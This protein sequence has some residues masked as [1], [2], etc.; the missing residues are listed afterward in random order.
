MVVLVVDEAVVH[1]D[2]ESPIG[3]GS[4]GVTLQA[5][6]GRAEGKSVGKGGLEVHLPARGVRE[7][8]C[9]EEVDVVALVG[10]LRYLLPVQVHRGFHQSE[11]DPRV[12]A[13]DELS[14]ELEVG[15]NYVTGCAVVAVI[16]DFQVIHVVGVQLPLCLVL[17]FRLE[18]VLHSRHHLERALRLDVLVELDGGVAGQGDGVAQFLVEGALVVESQGKAE[19]EVVVGRWHEA[20]ACTRADEP[21]LVPAPIAEAQAVVEAE[22]AQAAFPSPSVLGVHLELVGVD[23]VGIVYDGSYFRIIADKRSAFW[24]SGEV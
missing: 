20:Q 14:V 19:C 11:T 18:L 13:W 22:D 10:G 1:A 12:C 15:S 3:R 8:V 5:G 7:V 21:L 24:R 23:G 17:G 4:E 2:V 16:D 9:E 6:M